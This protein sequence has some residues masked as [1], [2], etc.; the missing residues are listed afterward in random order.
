VATAAIIMYLP[1][2][3]AL[4]A[5]LKFQEMQS[6]LVGSLPSAGASADIFK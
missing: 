1:Y 4:D 2:E 6:Q 3:R 5:D